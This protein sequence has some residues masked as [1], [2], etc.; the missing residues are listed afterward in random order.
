MHT[1]GPHARLPY[2]EYDYVTTDDMELSAYSPPELPQERQLTWQIVH[3]VVDGLVDLL[4]LKRKHREVAFKIKDGPGRVLVGY[5]H[6]IQRRGRYL[7]ID[8]GS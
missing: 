3:I 7:P 1:Y 4:I 6:L 2:G 8:R 5:G